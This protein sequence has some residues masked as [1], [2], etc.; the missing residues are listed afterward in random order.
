MNQNTREA[1]ERLLKVARSDS[2]QSKRVANF[3]LAW[4]NA[5]SC[6]G[7]DITDVFSVDEELAADMAA[8][9]AYVAS[10]SS[11][12]YPEDYRAEIE[13]IIRRWRPEVWSAGG[14]AE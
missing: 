12:E 4:W 14:D 7:F 8:I 10:R 2:G 5:A 9:F 3:I 1:F 11:P 13:E 6:G